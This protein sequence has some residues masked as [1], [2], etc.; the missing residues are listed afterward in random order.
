MIQI[1]STR[2]M[3]EADVIKSILEDNGISCVLWDSRIGTVYP[4]IQIRVMVQ[5][6]D[7][8]EAEKIIEDYQ[9]EN[10]KNED[11]RQINN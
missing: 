11:G 6:E 3:V 5:E 4:V 2:L 1:Y 8:E 7:F 9:R 10:K